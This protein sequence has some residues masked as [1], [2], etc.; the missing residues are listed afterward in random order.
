MEL[1]IRAEMSELAEILKWIRE[2]L[3]QTEL[4]DPDKKRVELSME[5]AIVNVMTHGNPAEIILHCR[6]DQAE[7]VEFILKD[8]G[9]PFNPITEAKV[10]PNFDASLEER[11]P[12]GL[13]LSIMR[14]YMD[15]LLY[16]RE[17]NLNILTLI[18]VIGY[19]P[20]PKS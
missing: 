15:L 2:Q 12:G 8:D 17:D 10:E 16:K 18:K 20:N 13:G 19:T 1:K 4:A 9:P 3:E 6:S 11:E 5:E 7:Q 14:N